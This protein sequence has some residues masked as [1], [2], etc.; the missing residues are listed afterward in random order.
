[1]LSASILAAWWLRLDLPG[2]FS[3]SPVKALMEGSSTERLWMALVILLAYLILRYH[4]SLQR[5]RQWRLGG[6]RVEQVRRHIFTHVVK[7]HLVRSRN[8]RTR[9]LLD[10]RRD[11]RPE[12]EYAAPS[13]LKTSSI[14]KLRLG[15]VTFRSALISEYQWFDDIPAAVEERERGWYDTDNFIEVE[16]PLYA[17]VPL[18]FATTISRLFMSRA[19]LEVV[20]PYLLGLT[21]IFICLLKSGFLEAI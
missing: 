3:L 8:K 10:R 5:V 14:Q 16:I 7:R 6:K 13:K 11:E 18:L 9:E 20:F 2:V 21:A 4:F 1:M 15:R 17:A 12:L 19:G